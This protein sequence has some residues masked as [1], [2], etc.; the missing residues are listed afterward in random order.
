MVGFGIN[1]STRN[2]RIISANRGET[3]HSNNVG[4]PSHLLQVRVEVKVHYYNIF[5]IDRY[6]VI[7]RHQKVEEHG[8]QDYAPH[9]I[10]SPEMR[11]EG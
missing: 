1:I 7:I 8:P 6:S 11:D 2:R 10:L 5:E 4:A 3:H 9:V